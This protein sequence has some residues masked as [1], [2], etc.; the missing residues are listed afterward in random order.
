MSK[1]L[2]A[3]KDLPQILDV[4]KTLGFVTVE[5]ALKKGTINEEQADAA[6]AS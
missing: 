2:E 3:M 6:R 1:H 5:V 4:Y